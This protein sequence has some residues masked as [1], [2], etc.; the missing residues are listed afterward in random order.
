MIK[1]SDLSVSF[2][3]GEEKLRILEKVGFSFENGKMT[4]V[5]GRS[6]SGKSTLL[7]VV[8]GILEP[9]EGNVCIDDAN[10][11]EMNADQRAAFRNSRI[12][13]VFQSFYL[14]K[15]L[16]ALENVMLPLIPQ[17]KKKTERYE[18]AKKALSYV[19]LENRE[20]HKPGQ[21]SGG[22]QQR[23]AIA[24]AI[25]TNPQYILADEPTG[26]LDSENSENIMRLLRK[27]ADEGKTV[28][29]VTHDPN[30]AKMCDK[31]VNISNGKIIDTEG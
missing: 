19:G 29:L 23:V 30:E 21:L 27:L 28:I 22:E 1:F 12:G 11:Y 2:K 13:F 18:L 14:D 31:M 6:G 5:T 9:D 8:G 26:N 17:K 4:A 7:N 16:T 10:I 25:V 20:K 15:N 3:S 24:R